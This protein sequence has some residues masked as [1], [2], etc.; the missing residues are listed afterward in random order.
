MI[1][2]AR[3]AGKLVSQVTRSP[4]WSAFVETS[5]ELRDLKTKIVNEAA[6]TDE[7]RKLEN[8]PE[9]FNSALN[10]FISNSNVNTE[11]IENQIENSNDESKSE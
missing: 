11:R 1:K 2:L 10:E 5:R 6:I 7:L 4:I 3:D 8:D 9:M